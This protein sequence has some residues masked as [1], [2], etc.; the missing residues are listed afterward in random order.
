[1]TATAAIASLQMSTEKQESSL[2]VRQG[3]SA[4]SHFILLCAA[5]LLP[6]CAT[7]LRTE[8]VLAGR[9]IE[10]T[11]GGTVRVLGEDRREYVV[12][13]AGVAPPSKPPF[14]EQS[15]EHLAQQLAGKAISVEWHKL[16]G[17]GHIV[18]RVF[19][20]AALDGKPPLEK[21]PAKTRLRA[22]AGML[23]IYSGMAWHD[24]QY[25]REQGELERSVYA[26]VETWACEARFGLWADPHPV[27]PWRSAASSPGDQEPGQDGKPIIGISA[28]YNG[29][30]VQ[31]KWRPPYE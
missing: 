24:R 10:V 18:G 23:Q 8:G 16:D 22:D 7:T 3:I 20:E 25:A 21:D 9:V 17:D 31:S 19:Y 15:R 11:D 6:A 29:Y 4:R 1:M 5:L 28:D 12:R 14:A 2:A 30:C 26:H 27:P 13:L